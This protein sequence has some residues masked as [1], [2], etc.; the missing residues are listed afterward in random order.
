MYQKTEKESS[1]SLT[2]VDNFLS[3]P[4][5]Y[6]FSSANEIDVLDSSYGVGVT[7]Y[8]RGQL[9]GVIYTVPAHGQIEIEF[10][11][12]LQCVTAASIKSM[13]ELIK[14]LLDASR[15]GKYEEMSRTS[16]S[17]G[18]GF[19]AFWSGG[20][21]ASYDQTKRRM[22]EWG[23]SEVNQQKIVEEM[24][25]LV[26]S[27]Q[28]FNYKGTVYNRDYDYDVTGSL[29]GVVMDCD[30]KQGTETKQVRTLAPQVQMQGSDGTSLPSVGALY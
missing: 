18:L 4:P 12:K 9:T 3:L 7:T 27:L 14:S 6:Y 26:N 21:R 30:I 16:V 20:V 25:K 28:E 22:E 5:V 23:L 11:L 15:R 8:G 29:F 19:F 10:K 1:I 2:V 24:L 17:G 13:D